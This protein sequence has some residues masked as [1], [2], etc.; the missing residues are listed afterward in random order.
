M[1]GEI[2]LPTGAEATVQARVLLV[3]NYRQHFTERDYDY[4]RF[5][6]DAEQGKGAKL[7]GKK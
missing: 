4:K 2:W 3:K 7:A 6:V 5:R 1:N